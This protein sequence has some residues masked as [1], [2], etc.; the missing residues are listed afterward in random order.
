[1]NK[2]EQKRHSPG[3]RYPYAGWGLIVGASIG[4]FVGMLFFDNLAMGVACGAGL[5]LIAGAAVS[6]HAQAQVV[7]DE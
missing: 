4:G 3:A 5:G 7:G 1:M 6:A 2:V